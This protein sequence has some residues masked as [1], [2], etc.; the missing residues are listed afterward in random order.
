MET[1]GETTISTQCERILVCIGANPRSLHLIQKAKQMAADLCADWLAVTVEAPVKVR[2]SE[3][4]LV[5]L[6][7]HMQV[8]ES[9]KAET[10]T[11]TGHSVSEELLSFARSRNVTRI[12][13]GKPT[14]PRWKD[15]LFGS[16]IDEVVRGSGDIDVY[17]VSAEN[18]TETVPTTKPGQKQTTRLRDWFQSLVHVAACSIVAALMFPHFTL[19]DLAMVYLLG[20]VLSASRLGR[21]PTLLTTLLSVAAFNFLF[22]PPLY[23]FTVEDVRYV[24]TF[25]VMFIVGYVISQLTLR[26]REQ[27]ISAQHREQRTAALYHLIRDL[28]HVE[29]H[30][31]L[32]STAVRHLNHVF[33]CQAVILIPDDQE[34]L[35]AQ[36]QEYA[37]AL[38]SKERE[39]ATWSMENRR[40]AGLGTDN[41]FETKALYLPLVAA[42][43]TIGVVALLPSGPDEMFLPE[44]LN[45]LESF[46]NQIAMALERAFLAEESQQVL[47]KVEAETL[48]N[49]LLSSV[50]HDLRTPLAAITGAGTTLLQG[51][52]LLNT[53]NRK[54]LVQTIVEEAAHLNRLIR[55]ILD[56]T[57]LESGEI[58]INKEWQSLEEIVG[59]VT[60]RMAA[61]FSSH[62]LIIQLPPELPLIFCDDLLIEQVLRNLMENAIKYAPSGSDVVLRASVVGQEVSVSVSDQGPGVSADDQTKIFEKFARGRHSVGGVGLGLAICKAVVAAHGGRIWAENLRGGGANFTFTLPVSS[63]PPEIEEEFEEEPKRAVKNNKDASDEQ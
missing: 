57:R 55:N 29:G 26:V 53:E 13:I 54:E 63:A 33:S 18:N 1:Q 44:Q 22:I 30:E 62:K 34:R 28:A 10:V 61:Q 12:I 4:D 51:E 50:S 5:Q 35:I 42:S 23:T 47:L 41:P 21:G 6:A 56:M 15:R 49:T 8:A 7:K 43:K 9:L 48:R 16:V 45:T 25:A 36:N 46:A 39:V 20:I 60:N 31:S 24:V 11:L 14:H 32:S 17:I 38:N 40:S 19:V 52:N 59:A 27:A 58:K 2:P 3:F 37:F